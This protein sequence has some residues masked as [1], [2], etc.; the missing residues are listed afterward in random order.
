MGRRNAT[1]W[2]ERTYGR[3]GGEGPTAGKKASTYRV[4]FPDG[5]AAEKRVFHAIAPEAT[6]YIYEHKGVWYCAGV[7]DTP[8]P[9]M[10]SYQTAAAERVR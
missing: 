4:R 10:A 6:A 7:H 2:I 9:Q 3:K 5:T 1:A 8:A